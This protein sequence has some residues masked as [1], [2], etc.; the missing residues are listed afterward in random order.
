VKEGDVV[1]REGGQGAG[2]RGEELG[3]GEAE[4][5]AMG[6]AEAVEFGDV[7]W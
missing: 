6:V 7:K 2:D 4:A 5:D 3:L 1:G